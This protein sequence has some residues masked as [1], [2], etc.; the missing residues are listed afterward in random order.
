[1]G[2]SLLREKLIVTGS[3]PITGHCAGGDVYSKNVSQ[4]FLRYGHFLS[5]L[6]YRS[7][8]T[9]F[10]ISH[11][12]NFSVCSCIF[13]VSVRGEKFGSLVI[14]VQSLN[15]TPCNIQ[16]CFPPLYLI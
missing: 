5:F 9:S 15:E 3:L 13:G 6:I 10:S 16:G 4:P 2:G 7:H 12:R 11:R 14:L 8:S 1:M